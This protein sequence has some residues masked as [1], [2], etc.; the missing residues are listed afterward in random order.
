MVTARCHTFKAIVAASAPAFLP[1]A[2][3]VMLVK[4][5]ELIFIIIFI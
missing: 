4:G 1:P 3:H 5:T 2:K